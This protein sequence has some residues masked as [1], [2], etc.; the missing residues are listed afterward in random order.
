VG[1][2]WSQLAPHRSASGTDARLPAL[3]DAL[4]AMTQPD[5]ERR[6]ASDALQL[7]S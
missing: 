1:R 5:P 6:P 3:L 7:P 2:L 4:V